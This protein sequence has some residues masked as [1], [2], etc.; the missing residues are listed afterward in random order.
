MSE[1]QEQLKQKLESLK[2][3]LFEKSYFFGNVG[4]GFFTIENRKRRNVNGIKLER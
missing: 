1:F 2:E 3:E 4:D